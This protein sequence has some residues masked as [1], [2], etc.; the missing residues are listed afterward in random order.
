MFS[1]I[2]EVR[3][4]EMCLAKVRG[5]FSSKGQTIVVIRRES[6]LSSDSRRTSG[7][8]IRSPSFQTLVRAFG[9]KSGLL[10]GFGCSVSIF[11]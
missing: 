4:L 5:S 1:F 9:P 7:G 3:K 11:L 6:V 2:V 10:N 8:T